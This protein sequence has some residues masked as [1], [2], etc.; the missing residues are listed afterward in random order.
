MANKNTNYIGYKV[1]KFQNQP[2][3]IEDVEFVLED[4]I[5]FA[6]EATDTVSE[7]DL[8]RKYVTLYQKKKY[9]REEVHKDELAMLDIWTKSVRG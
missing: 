2:I 9:N 5:E 4:F 6:D 3:P 8:V 1:K 7:M